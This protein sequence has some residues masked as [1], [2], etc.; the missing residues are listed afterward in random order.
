[1][2]CKQMITGVD[3]CSKVVYFMW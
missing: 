2:I 1:M 3:K